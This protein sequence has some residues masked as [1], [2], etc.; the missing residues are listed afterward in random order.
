MSDAP[1]PRRRVLLLLA[2]L[3]IWLGSVRRPRSAPDE[4]NDRGIGGTGAR[5][6]GDETPEGDR[7]IG[8]TGVISTIRRY[9]SIVVNDLR[10]GYSRD[11]SMRIDGAP[12]KA[13]DL[14][15]GHVVRLVASEPPGPLATWAIEVTSEV[16]GPVEAAG[17]G[18]L[19]VLGQAVSVAAG[20]GAWKVGDRVAVCGLRT[21]RSSRARSR[22]A[23]RDR[24]GSPA[25][26]ARAP[27]ACR[28]SGRCGSTG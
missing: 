10:I 20:S 28:R 3:P 1:S 12:A 13:S 6:T 25:R 4:P 16:V 5:P 15:V 11:V 17:K 21:G 9:G 19:T 24:R 18:R 22:R 27:T 8:G 14:K 7:G 2:G 23:R 26:S